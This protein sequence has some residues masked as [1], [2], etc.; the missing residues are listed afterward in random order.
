MVPHRWNSRLCLHLRRFESVGPYTMDCSANIK[1]NNPYSWL[2]LLYDCLLPQLLS[3]S[4]FR[5][6]VGISDSPVVYPRHTIGREIF[7][8]D[9]GKIPIEKTGMMALVVALPWV[10]VALLWVM[11]E[12]ISF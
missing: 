2:S 12:R 3:E 9:S 5:F 7:P 4:L 8:S 6:S 10:I 11:T 1:R